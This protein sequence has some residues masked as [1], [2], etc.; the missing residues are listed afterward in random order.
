MTPQMFHPAPA[1]HLLQVTPP[2][3][4]MKGQTRR[5]WED[6][7]GSP[8]FSSSC[9]VPGYGLCTAATAARPSLWKSAT[10]PRQPAQPGRAGNGVK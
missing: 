7:C 3:F 4:L 1:H 2:V 9:A 8:V 6:E 5:Q 10:R